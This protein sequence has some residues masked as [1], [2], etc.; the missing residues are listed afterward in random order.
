MTERDVRNSSRFENSSL[1]GGYKPAP[2]TKAVAV[3]I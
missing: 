3:P 1:H 2:T